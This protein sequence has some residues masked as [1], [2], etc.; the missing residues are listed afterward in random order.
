[1][2][3]TR[4]FEADLQYQQKIRR[5]EDG[6]YLARYTIVELMPDNVQEIMKG[7]Y[8]CRSRQ[9]LYRWKHE[10]VEQIINLANIL[11]AEEGSYSSDRAY[12]PLC[13]Q[14]TSSPYERGFSVPEGLRRHLTGRGNSQQCMVMQAAMSLARD[15]WQSQYTDAVKAE[16]DKKREELAQ[17]KK[18]EVLYRI[19]PDLEPELI[20]ERL[21]FG[22]TPRS[23]GE[24]DWVEARLTSLGFQITWDGNAKSYTHEHGDFVVYAD[25]R[26]SGRVDFSVFPK[27]Y[28][29]SRGRLRLCWTSFYILDG[30][31]KE[32]REKYEVRVGNAVSQLKKRQ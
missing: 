25:P 26:Q 11:S 22:G 15:C 6:L 29:R 31:K 27:D 5:L 3:R 16:E 20:D 8:S 10:V 18:S 12:C 23:E 19:A 21:R 2:R 28:K 9:E 13:G 1:M 7:Y 32:L 17:R 30:W 14:G 4:Y 24:L